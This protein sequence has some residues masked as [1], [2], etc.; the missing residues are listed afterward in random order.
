MAEAAT[1]VAR[2]RDASIRNSRHLRGIDLVACEAGA[3]I[4][5]FALALPIILALLAGCYAV[6]RALLVRQVMVEAVHAGARYLARIPDPTCRPVCSAA[7]ERAV[8][9]TVEQIAENARVPVDTISVSPRPP[10]SDET[11]SMHAEVRLSVE[12]LSVFGLGP[13]VT[14][15]ATQREQR[16]GE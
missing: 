7:A 12:L 2:D 9:T 8:A 6:G 4:L 10:A 13:V 11:V 15:R 5:E 3:A 16:I 1:S 14:L